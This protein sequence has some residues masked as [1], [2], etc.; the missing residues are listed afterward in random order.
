MLHVAGPHDREESHR[1][2]TEPEGAAERDELEPEEIKDLDVDEERSDEV[3][4]GG[5]YSTLVNP[6]K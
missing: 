4:G 3:L 2:Y 1:D 6:T 5:V